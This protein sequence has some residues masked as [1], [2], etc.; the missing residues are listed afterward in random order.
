[1]DAICIEIKNRKEE[2][3][4]DK[5]NTIYFGGG[6]PSVLKEKDFAKIL[7]TILIQANCNL[8]E[9]TVEAN[10]DDINVNFLKSMQ[11]LQVN[12]FS[13]GIQSFDDNV[14]KWM[15][16]AHNFQE[17][18][19]CIKI[20]QDFGF[21]NLT[22]DLIYGIPETHTH[23]FADTLNQFFNYDVPH[24][25]AYAL[26]VEENTALHHSI[27]NKKN[28]SVDE[29]LALKDFETLT[30]LSKS[31]N[32]DHY[33]LSNFAKAEK[34]AMHNTNYW[35]GEHYF[36]FGPAAHSFSNN[37]RRWNVSNNAKYLKAITDKTLF[38]EEETLSE[39][40]AFNE[41]IMIGLR[42]KWGIEKS[43]MENKFNSTIVGSFLKDVELELNNK[44]IVLKKG[45]YH[46]AA[47]AKFIS[48]RVISNLFV[49]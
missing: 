37:K 10:P 16:R 38:F 44:N 35:K 25:S 33:E 23:Y 22:C 15:N 34:Y 17:S 9:V 29:K 45:R 31:K 12:R 11:A 43:E 8:K 6:T 14:L 49:L 7:D 26:T 1:M 18:D 21:E 28:K 32:Y 19:A 41:F 39:Q 36:G 2:Y 13:I 48:D 20:S 42:T 40:E 24:L 30:A 4:E 27:K 3:K 46:I 47:K 5:I